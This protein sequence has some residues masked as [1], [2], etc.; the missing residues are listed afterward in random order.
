MFWV[1]FVFYEYYD[2]QSVFYFVTILLS[3]KERHMVK[4]SIF[5]RTISLV[6]VVV[7]SV[8]SVVQ[9]Q[10]IGKRS[11]RTQHLMPYIADV[12]KPM[13]DAIPTP[14]GMRIVTDPARAND[15]YY[16]NNI[17]FVPGTNKAKYLGQ[18][19]VY[20][21]KT[22]QEVEVLFGDDHCLPK[23]IA[24]VFK[25][26]DGR[27]II[28]HAKN[29]YQRFVRRAYE[30]IR[31]PQ[32]YLWHHSYKLHL[33][34]PLMKMLAFIRS[35]SFVFVPLGIFCGVAWGVPEIVLFPYLSL[36]ANLFHENAHAIAAVHYGAHDARK[37]ITFKPWKFFNV[38]GYIIF[39]IAGMV[40]A[41]VGFNASRLTTK[42]LMNILMAG[43]V[44]NLLIGCMSLFMSL[45]L[46]GVHIYVFDMSF[47]VITLNLF[48]IANFLQGA[49]TLIPAP[50]QDG[51]QYLA[52]RAKLRRERQGKVEH[53][54]REKSAEDVEHDEDVDL[55]CYLQESVA[56]MQKLRKWGSVQYQMV[57]MVESFPKWIDR[58]RNVEAIKRVIIAELRNKTIAK[59]VDVDILEW[60]EERVN[61]KKLLVLMLQYPSA[62]LALFTL[63]W[64][65]SSGLRHNQRPQNDDAIT[66]PI[67]QDKSVT[68]S[69]ALVKAAEA[70]PRAEESSIKGVFFDWGNVVTKLDYGRLSAYIA[71]TYSVDSGIVER[72]FEDRNTVE[73]NP[74]YKYEHGL[75]DE[76]EL[77]GALTKWINAVSTSHDQ[78]VIS[79]DDVHAIYN[80]IWD[81]QDIHETIFLMKGL[82]EKG[83]RLRMISTTSEIHFRHFLK[84]SLA[85]QLL[86]DAKSF[87]AS[88]LQDPENIKPATGSYLSVI[89]DIEAQQ[90]HACRQAGRGFVPGNFLFVDDLQ[91]NVDGALAAGLRG[92]V[93]DPENPE[94]SVLD[95]ISLLSD[96]ALQTD[97]TI[98]SAA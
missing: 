27:I 98:L 65:L 51:Y 1:T 40:S 30:L 5:I 3:K 54:H 75:C 70:I 20:E 95:I 67:I 44:C 58:V 73:D 59:A 91:V 56:K 64:Y 66:V 72:F 11:V 55:H 32:G 2:K 57:S 25:L 80:V 90:D 9:A 10:P 12:Q 18:T 86:D 28:L 96:A 60:F 94:K 26:E 87:Y 76:A 33:S 88:H 71:E 81:A 49:G 53:D 97:S 68:V 36:L 79:V 16:P 63:D 23:R 14:L 46:G 7:F 52:L 29:G 69:T 37:S 82:K 47:W 42:Q 21:E 6:T 13:Q 17:Y 41:Q 39:P 89:D 8:V 62:S 43:P 38:E 31:D 78:H 61:D 4:T 19:Y 15:Y 93:F 34:S 77:A 74:V 48:C 50:G 45:L 83:Y 85:A 35:A 84:H 22:T 24:Y 92:F